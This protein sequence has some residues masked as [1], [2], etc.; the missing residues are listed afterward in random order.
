MM[1]ISNWGVCVDG[2]DV[3]LRHRT[4][5]PAPSTC[6]ARV[7]RSRGQTMHGLPHQPALS[8][9]P[10]RPPLKKSAV[11]PRH[12]DLVPPFRYC[13]AMAAVAVSWTECR[14]THPHSSL[15]ALMHVS[16]R[17]CVSGL[18][19]FLSLS[20]SSPSLPPSLSLPPSPSHPHPKLFRV[21]DH[22]S[23]SSG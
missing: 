12:L 1:I 11:T 8:S 10:A 13:A 20:L 2:E 15:S 9:T 17:V 19:P 22:I 4:Q 16:A 21:C 14:P 6:V 3:C 23:T 7:S 5:A 18:L